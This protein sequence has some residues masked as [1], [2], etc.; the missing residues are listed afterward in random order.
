MTAN[1]CS[2]RTADD[3]VLIPAAAGGVG[4]LAVQLA[5]HVGATVV[6]MASSEEKR[7]TARQLGADAVVD[8]LTRNV[9]DEPSFT[10]QHPH[11]GFT[12]P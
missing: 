11:A 10:E 6:A 5:K 2:A 12:Q 9:R 4:S 7:S 3:T 1:S 8:S